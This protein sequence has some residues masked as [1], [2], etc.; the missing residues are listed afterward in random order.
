MNLISYL[1]SISISSHST[2][3]PSDDNAQ[4]Q[5]QTANPFAAFGGFLT[6]PAA[7]SIMS[8]TQ[9][10]PMAP[11]STTPSSV[12]AA[13][14]SL[15][16]N[17]FSATGFPS[18]ASN[19]PAFGTASSTAS[20][21]SFGPSSSLQPPALTSAS[22]QSQFSSSFLQSSTSTLTS[23]SAAVAP[24]PLTFVSATSAIGS[25]FANAAASRPLGNGA[26]PSAP[27]SA[28]DANRLEFSEKVAQLNKR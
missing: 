26:S 22:S 9:P 14:P 7:S 8:T 17:A 20:L 6:A 21:T 11:L 3:K 1:Y 10:R 19:Q 25:S 27:T 24:P 13:A 2:Q 23:V 4:P 12:S 16:P 18:F 5:V 28:S 15:I